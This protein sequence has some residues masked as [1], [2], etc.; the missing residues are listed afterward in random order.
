MARPN[1]FGRYTPIEAPNDETFRREQYAR[2]REDIDRKRRQIGVQ[3]NVRGYHKRFLEITVPYIF[4]VIFTYSLSLL[5]ECLISIA[6]LH[7]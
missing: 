4:A 1:H 5:K 2:L 7:K 3:P 6:P